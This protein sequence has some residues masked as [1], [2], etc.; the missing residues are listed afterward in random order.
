MTL[1]NCK[2]L[3]KHYQDLADGTISKPFGH[4]DWADVIENAKVRAKVMED[5]IE[6]KMNHRK[7]AHLKPKEQPKKEVKKNAKKA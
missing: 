7:Y 1:E 4:K 5:R 2:R 3:L 6:R